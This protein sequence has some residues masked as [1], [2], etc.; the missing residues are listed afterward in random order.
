MFADMFEVGKDLSVFS[1]KDGGAAGNEQ[2]DCEEVNEGCPVLKRENSLPNTEGFEEF[3]LLREKEG[4]PAE[5][6]EEWVDFE[7]GQT[8]PDFGMRGKQQPIDFLEA[9][10]DSVFPFVEVLNV[11]FDQ[12]CHDIV[13]HEEAG[14]LIH[15]LPADCP[16]YQ[17]EDRC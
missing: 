16:I 8:V 3:E 11:E 6:V 1:S 7:E 9:S 4:E 12:V 10:V 13:E 5:G 2:L 14:S 15:I 17:V